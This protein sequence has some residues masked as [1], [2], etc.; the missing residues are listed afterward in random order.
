MKLPDY[1]GI[2]RKEA[3]F[4]EDSKFHGNVTDFTAVK[5]ARPWT[6]G[7]QFILNKYWIVCLAF[8]VYRKVKFTYR[9]LT[10]SFICGWD[11]FILAKIHAIAKD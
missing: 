4:T 10:G 8:L 3:N 1:T 9:N 7:T 2:S 6:L 5:F 11:L